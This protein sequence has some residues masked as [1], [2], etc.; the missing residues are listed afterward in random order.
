MHECRVRVCVCLR[1]CACARV[2]AGGG[3]RWGCGL[4]LH[5]TPTHLQARLAS[6]SCL[7]RERA[8]ALSGGFNIIYGSIRQDPHSPAGPPR[9]CHTRS[10]ARGRHPGWPRAP[11][12]GCLQYSSSAVVLEI[13]HSRQHTNTPSP[14]RKKHYKTGHEHH[15]EVACRNASQHQRAEQHALATGSTV[16]GV[17]HSPGTD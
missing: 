10:P 7:G 16:R 14:P 8:L 11:W 3:W 5:K 1:V 4:L 13:A 9:S 2:S 17:R 12:G 6:R 15:G